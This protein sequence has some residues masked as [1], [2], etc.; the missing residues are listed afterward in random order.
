MRSFS[1]LMFALRPRR[2]HCSAKQLP[3]ELFVPELMVD[4]PADE[5]AEKEGDAAVTAAGNR[6]VEGL[7]CEALC[8]TVPAAANITTRLLPELPATAGTGEKLFVVLL[9]CRLLVLMRVSVVD[10]VGRRP[11]QRRAT[12]SPC[13]L[14]QE[15]GIVKV[16]SV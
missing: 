7:A 15:S 9:V 8:P 1:S 6:F 13:R 3:E 2:F 11:G 5:S 4:L 16:S 10:C 12:L 14:A